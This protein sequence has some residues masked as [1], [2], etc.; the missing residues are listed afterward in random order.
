MFFFTSATKYSQTPSKWLGWPDF[1]GLL[2]ESGPE[3][4]NS[5]LWLLCSPSAKSPGGEKDSL[6]FRVP[7][8]KVK[9]VKDKGNEGCGRIG[10]KL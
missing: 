10:R 6:I 7:K 8:N 1:E 4:V 2:K 3:K 5:Y 9:R